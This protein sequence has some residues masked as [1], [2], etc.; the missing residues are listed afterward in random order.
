[1]MFRSRSRKVFAFLWDADGTIV[2]SEKFAYD[3]CNEALKHLSKRT[4][5]PEEFRELFLSDYRT[6][7]KHMGIDSVQEVEFFVNVWN[8][9]LTADEHKFKLHDG[10]LDILTYLHRRSYK[11]ALV[12]ATSRLQLQRY[13]NL[14]GIDKFFSVIIAR[15]DVEEQK[16]STKPILQAAEQLAVSPED[17]VVIDDVDDGIIAARKIGAITIGVTWGFN[18]YQRIY[19]A[20]P[21]FI[22]E[23]ASELYRI[24]VEKLKC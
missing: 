5:A 21:D 4:F 22:A 13:F 2:S 19:D 10:V 6:H 16:P 11:M 3:A 1:M 20:K 7:L 23:T 18:S 12:S 17:C 8:S 9:R 24:V 15:E 14:F